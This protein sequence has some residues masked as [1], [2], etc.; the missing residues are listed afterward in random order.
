MDRPML[1]QSF[2]IFYEA[3]KA[4]CY[5]FNN[6]ATYTHAVADTDEGVRGPPP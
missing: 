1:R 5:K 3:E 6:S 4:P 2:C